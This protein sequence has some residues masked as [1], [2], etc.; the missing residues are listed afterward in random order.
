MGIPSYFRKLLQRHGQIV[1]QNGPSKVGVLAMDFNCLIYT[2]A[3][4]REDYPVEGGAEAKEAWEKSL[5][6]DVAA[7]MVAIWKR[8]G[9]PARTIVCLDG[10]V[11]M[12]KVRQQRMRRFK[13]VWIKS[14]EGDKGGGWDTNCITPGTAFMRTLRAELVRVS[15][16]EMK[17]CVISGTDE[18]G[19][20]EHK[21]MRWIRDHRGELKAGE[22]IIVYGLDADLIL[23]TMI[24][25]TL[26]PCP[27]YL[28]REH[29]EFK[30]V[31]Q[32]LDSQ[33]LTYIY[34]NLQML[35]EKLGIHDTQTTMNYIGLM[36]FMGNDFLPHSLTH[37]LTDDGHECVM[38]ELRRGEKVVRE[39]EGRWRYD[40][41]VV[42]DI[43]RR[44]SM[45]EEERMIRMIESKRSARSRIGQ[46]G[47]DGKP[48]AEYETLPLKWDVEKE[49]LR[50]GSK[51][52]VEGW[53]D[54]YL[55]W[56]HP[57][58][59]EGV[60]SWSCREYVG[61][62]DWILQY[63]TGH[64][65]SLDWMFPSWTPPLWS[66]IVRYLEGGGSVSAAE[67]G[68]GGEPLKP[69][70]QLALVL[71]RESWGL[72]EEVLY[73]AIPSIAPQFFPTRF[74]VHSVGKRMMWECEALLPVFTKERLR[75][76]VSRENRDAE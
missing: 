1:S 4:R 25:S 59:G 28:L 26:T 53:R 60:R 72:I 8:V 33:E 35:K 44:W 14:L 41:D 54:I 3:R 6:G 27:I 46:K 38:R 29:M 61:G 67:V 18:P 10:V 48:L 47:P 22:A 49:I 75:Q 34:L 73:K 2:V 12:A 36:S 11:P 45:E 5:C 17:G 30:G 19:E 56:I 64:E 32:G 63:Y 39:V 40:V 20:G 16:R 51:E 68:N 71:P 50:E 9:K 52:L 70:E 13:S 42:V 24:A 62:L 57:R 37:R 43:L 31:V 55:T 15:Q 7:E 58:G 23:L 69:I 66:E 76:I 21:I 74:E 65:V